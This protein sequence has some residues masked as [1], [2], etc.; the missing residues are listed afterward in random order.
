MCDGGIFMRAT[1]D[2]PQSAWTWQR[3]IDI[4]ELDSDGATWRGA[5]KLAMEVILSIKE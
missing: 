4:G 5:R 1:K 3:L 2:L